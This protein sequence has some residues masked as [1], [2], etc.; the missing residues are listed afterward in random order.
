VGLE[1]D[2]TARSMFAIVFV[3]VLT[4]VNS[5]NNTAHW[6]SDQGSRI[7]SK[8]FHTNVINIVEKVPNTH[9][10]YMEIISPRR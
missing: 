5:V 10:T 8:T 4:S 2:K 6:S 7:I 1:F 3:V 9:A